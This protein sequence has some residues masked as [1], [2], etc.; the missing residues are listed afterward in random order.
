MEDNW[1]S[2]EAWVANFDILGFKSIIEHKDQSFELQLLKRKLDEVIKKLNNEIVQKIEYVDY[3]HYS[4]TFIIYSK[5]KEVSDY[6]PFIRICKN[7]IVNCFYKRLPIRGAI[8]YGEL[9]FGHRKKVL[10]GKAFLESYVYGEDQNWLG[11]ILSPSASSKLISHN[12]D[13]LRH[14]FI[15]KDIPMRAYSIFDREIYAYRFIEHKTPLLPI[16]KE[17]F[18]KTPGKE[19]VK[20]KNTIEF[21]EKH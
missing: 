12:L 20:Y 2:Y 8:S 9:V 6:L 1:I 13:P 7:F 4:D 14:G 16:L 3:Q 17:M 21:I 18:S 11:L 19:K 10:I 5:S 15:N